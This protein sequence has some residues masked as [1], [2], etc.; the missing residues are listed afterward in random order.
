MAKRS[1]SGLAPGWNHAAMAR[2]KEHMGLAPGARAPV[3]D[4]SSVNVMS[5][6]EISVGTSYYLVFPWLP[7]TTP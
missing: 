4:Y 1:E 2:P 7:H 5:Y 6:G 3:P